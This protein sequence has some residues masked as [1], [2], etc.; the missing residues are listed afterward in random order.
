VAATA[1]DVSSSGGL[2]FESNSPL[3]TGIATRYPGDAGIE[4]HP[5]VVFVERFE[6]NTLTDLFNRWTDILNGS[7]MAFNA[8][9]PPGSAGTRSL[10]IPWVGGGVNNRRRSRLGSCGA[11]PRHLTV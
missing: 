2:V 8:D 6:E 9:V 11:I 3:S 4:T 7:T 1:I 5:N 10:N